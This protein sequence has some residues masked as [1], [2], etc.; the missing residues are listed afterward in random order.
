M[1]TVTGHCNS[2]PPPPSY[3]ITRE[4]K[5]GEGVLVWQLDNMSVQWAGWHGGVRGGEEPP[6]QCQ[7]RQRKTIPPISR[8]LLQEYEHIKETEITSASG[9]WKR[10]SGRTVLYNIQYTH[11]GAASHGLGYT[12]GGGGGV[13]GRGTQSCPPPLR[14]GPG[15]HTHTQTYITHTSYI[16]TS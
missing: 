3:I 8:G 2:P 9:G 10:G 7:G 5:G 11:T 13:G 6:P 12:G 15:S 4:R 1:N 16:Y 14:P